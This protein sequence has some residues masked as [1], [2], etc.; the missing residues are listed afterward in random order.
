MFSPPQLAFLGQRLEE[1]TAAAGGIL[2]IGC[3]SGHT[4]VFLNRWLD[5]IE[6]ERPYAAIDTFAGFTDDD[7][8]AEFKR[9]NSGA[10][11]LGSF[12]RVGT[13]ESFDNRMETNDVKRVR[14]VQGD[15][16][17]FDY[18]PYAPICFALIDVDLYRPVKAALDAIGDLVSPGG[19]VVVDDCLPSGGHFSGAYD[20]YKEYCEANSLPLDIQHG[21]LGVI[22]K[23]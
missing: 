12:F 4:T 13:Q 8:D 2:E 18:R 20:A 14:S 5:A 22:R 11:D 10:R 19:I 9:G 15:A 16:A 23:V 7:I 3:A 6:V 21:K 1:A 17:T